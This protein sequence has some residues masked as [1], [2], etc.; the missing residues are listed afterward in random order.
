MLGNDKRKSKKATLGIF[1]V[2]RVIFTKPPK[3]I[4]NFAGHCNK[5]VS[6]KQE[7]FYIES[8]ISTFASLGMRINHL[9]DLWN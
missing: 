5:D 2:L 6:L 7:P 8:F 3:L 9:R 4:N 1:K